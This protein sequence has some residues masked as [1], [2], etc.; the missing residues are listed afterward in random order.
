MPI[1]DEPQSSKDKDKV[2]K[3]TEQVTGDKKR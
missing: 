1:A 3:Q 2:S